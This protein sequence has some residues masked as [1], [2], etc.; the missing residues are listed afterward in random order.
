M[1]A[2]ALVQEKPQEHRRTALVD[3]SQ[4]DS[5]LSADVAAVTA[6]PQSKPELVVSLRPLKTVAD[7]LLPDHPLRILLSGEPENLPVEEYLLKL[8]GWYRLLRSEE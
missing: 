8:P 3:Y 4:D 1:S 2:V 7:K 5:N 6:L